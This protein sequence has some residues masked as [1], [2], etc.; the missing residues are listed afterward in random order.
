MQQKLSVVRNTKL[1]LIGY[2]I[3]KHMFFNRNGSKFCWQ[4][5]TL[6][7]WYIEHTI[8]IIKY[9]YLLMHSFINKTVYHDCVR[10]CCFYF[11]LVNAKKFNTIQS[12]F[13]TFCKKRW[14]LHRFLSCFHWVTFIIVMPAAVNVTFYVVLE[15]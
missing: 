8:K 14:K 4:S 3:T 9:L 5:F 2:I 7:T 10:F 11:I 6:N 15:I 1:Y 13:I 12:S